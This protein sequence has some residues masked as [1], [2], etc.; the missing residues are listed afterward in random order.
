MEIQNISPKALDEKISR[1]EKLFLIDTLPDDH[2][3][4]VRLPGSCNAC[5]YQANF[6]GQV[7][8]ITEDREA[9]I[10]VYGSSPDPGMPPLPLKNCSGPVT[11][12]L[13]CSRA[14]S[15]AGVPPA[16]PSREAGRGWPSIR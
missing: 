8:S 15:K 10:V 4:R 2:F 7:Q 11:G 1:G 3:Q 5:V 9:E 16:D 6:L 12:G 14:G 13:P